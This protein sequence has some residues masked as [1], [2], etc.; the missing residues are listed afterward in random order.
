[1]AKR[2]IILII[3]L[4][5]VVLILSGVLAYKKDI[6]STGGYIYILKPLPTKVPVLNGPMCGWCGN[7]CVN[8]KVTNARTTRCPDVIPTG[9][10]QCVSENGACVLKGGNFQTE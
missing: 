1:M 2:N 6:F 5:A 8:W 3:V 9:G 4:V 10:A 7:S